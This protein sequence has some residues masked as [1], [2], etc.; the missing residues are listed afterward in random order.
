MNV[1]AEIKKKKN[2][3]LFIY[4][5]K[6]NNIENILKINEIKSRFFENIN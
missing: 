6:I 3:Y 2:I 1:R 4:R 5:K